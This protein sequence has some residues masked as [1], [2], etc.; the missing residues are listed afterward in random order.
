VSLGVLAGILIGSLV[1]L[2][3]GDAALDLAH[4]FIDRL[5]GRREQV[6]FEL[7]LQ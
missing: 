3:L 7:L 4:R 1:T 5:A 6:R 2:W